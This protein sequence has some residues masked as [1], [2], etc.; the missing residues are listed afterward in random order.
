MKNIWRRISGQK[1]LNIII[2]NTVHNNRPLYLTSSSY[3]LV[4]GFLEML[5]S[6]NN[7]SV[8]FQCSPV[9]KCKSFN[10]MFNSVESCDKEKTVNWKLGDFNYTTSFSQRLICLTFSVV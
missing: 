2:G 9:P 4:I 5:T 6:V 1:V 8:K 3:G 10:L 7:L